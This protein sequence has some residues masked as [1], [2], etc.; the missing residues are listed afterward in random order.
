LRAQLGEER[1]GEERRGEERRG[2]ERRGEQDARRGSEE[3]DGGHVCAA[4]VGGMWGVGGMWRR[5][6]Y[7]T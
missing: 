7:N 5:H 6:L 2:E 1:R 4:R 3:R